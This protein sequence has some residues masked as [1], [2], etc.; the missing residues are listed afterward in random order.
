MLPKHNRKKH[1][2]AKQF[3]N[4]TD[5]GT[6]MMK[7]LEKCISIEASKKRKGE[8]KLEEESSRFV[9]TRPTERQW[10]WIQ[11]RLGKKIAMFCLE[12]VAVI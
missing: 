1:R 8:K 2:K 10:R 4:G 7:F 5:F 9:A 6:M 3:A 11:K 12:V